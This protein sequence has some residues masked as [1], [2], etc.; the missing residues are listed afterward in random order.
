MNDYFWGLVVAVVLVLIGVSAAVHY[1]GSSAQGIN[2]PL[3]NL[4]REM[5]KTS[6]G[7]GVTWS[8]EYEMPSPFEDRSA[9][10]LKK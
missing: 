2:P 4:K 5:H 1:M 7:Y 3:K 8:G 10:V 9:E 6:D